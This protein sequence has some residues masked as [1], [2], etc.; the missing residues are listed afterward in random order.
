MLRNRIALI[1]VAAVAASACGKSRAPAGDTATSGAR[2]R[3]NGLMTRAPPRATCVAPRSNRMIASPSRHGGHRAAARPRHRRLQP[4]GKAAPTR[5]RALALLGREE[6]RDFAPTLAAEHLQRIGIRV[7][8]ET[9]R[10]W[11]IEAGLWRARRQKVQAVHVWRER[12]RITQPGADAARIGLALT[13]NGTLPSV[14]AASVC[15]YA[16]RA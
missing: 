4:L 11:Q 16:P 8:R 1:A 2:R 10:V 5:E 13:S 12:L 3:K 14:C 7:S 6:Y 15:T 9:V